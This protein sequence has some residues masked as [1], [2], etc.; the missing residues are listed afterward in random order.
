[1]DERRE[2]SL[3]GRD[4]EIVQVLLGDFSLLIVLICDELPVATKSGGKAIKCTYENKI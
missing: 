1:V 4:R 3:F 2:E